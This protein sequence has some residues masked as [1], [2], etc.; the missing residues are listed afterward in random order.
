MKKAL[1]GGLLGLFIGGAVMLFFSWVEGIISFHLV[2]PGIEKVEI[3]PQTAVMLFQCLLTGT[4]TGGITYLTGHWG[5]GAAFGIVTGYGL[6]FFFMSQNDQPWEMIRA[7]GMLLPV[8]LV[9]VLSSLTA[10]ML[11]ARNSI[12]AS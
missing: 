12:D 1:Y 2:P 11:G 6:G 10:A 3:T 5:L 7:L 4:I 8:L 9:G